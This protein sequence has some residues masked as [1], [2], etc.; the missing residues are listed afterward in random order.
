MRIIGGNLKSRRFVV[1]PN[2]PSRPT[3]DFAK[4]G[5]FNVLNHIFTFEK[6][7]ILDLC[8]GTGNLTFEFISR[9]SQKVTSVDQNNTCCRWIKKNAEALGINENLRILNM[10][11]VLFLKKDMDKYDLIVADPPYSTSFHN[12]IVQHVFS[13][14]KLNIDGFLVIEHGK[15]TDLSKDSRYLYTRKFGSVHFSFFQ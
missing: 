14:D 1:P 9:G 8:A 13:T 15:R 7:C 4:E 3:T 11:C 12:D 5:L 2:F 6:A 10:D